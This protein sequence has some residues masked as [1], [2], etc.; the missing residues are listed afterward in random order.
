MS[1]SILIN[2]GGGSAGDSAIDAVRAALAD[3]RLDA[4][5]EQ[6]PGPDLAG[7]AAALA[8]GGA[9]LV[10]AAGGD[11]T[12]GAVAGALAGTATSLGVLPLG[13]LNHLAR[14]L[15]IA[16]DIDQAVALL[17]SG[18]P[19]H[20]DLA[21]LNGR[22]FVNNSAIGLYPLMVVDRE[23]Q[24]KQ[25]RSKKMAMLVASLRT[26]IRFRHERLCLRINDSDTETLTTPLLFVG[27]NDYRMAWPAAGQREVIDDG[28]L[29]VL[30][31]RKTSRLGLFAA[32]LRLLMGRPRDDDMVRLDDVT[33]LNVSSRKARLTVS[34][35]GETERVRP[36]LD[37]RI[38]PR[39]LAVIA[40]A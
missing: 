22:Y 15:G 36:P 21:S 3:H 1:F 26:L 14:D 8:K 9:K 11:G 30:V 38:H 6:V 35:D 12:V 4:I 2:P 40:P 23:Q 20:I 10:V 25:G 39:A 28:R 19:R 32:T 16:F 29:C 31:M 33:R 17:A 7:R 13:T 24:Q 27:N 37:Y 34:S 5:I 18:R